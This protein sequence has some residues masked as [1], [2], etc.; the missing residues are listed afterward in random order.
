M[1][2]ASGL[3]HTTGI[4]EESVYGTANTTSMRG[5][6]VDSNSLA[7]SK[8]RAVGSG[9]RGGEL[10]ARASRTA[11]TSVMAEGEIEMDFATKGMG[12]WLRHC[13]GNSGISQIG[14]SAA[15]L[16]TFN[17][18]D[19]R[20]R[21]LTIMA[22]HPL[23][24][25]SLQPFTFTGCKVTEW[26]AS[27]GQGELLKFNASIDAQNGSLEASY[28]APSYT[29]ADAAGVLSWA[30]ASIY[31]NGSVTRTTGP[32]SFEISSSNGLATDRPRAGI[33]KAEPLQ[34]GLTETTVTIDSEFAD[35]ASWVARNHTDETFAVRVDF[36]GN[37]IT[38]A[39]AERVSFLLP[40]VKVNSEDPTVDG[41]DMLSQSIQLSA[42]SN[43][44]LS[45]IGVEYVSTDAA[46]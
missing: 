21:A 20:G 2:L 44:V 16:Q 6:Y 7:W 22:G 28:A 8:N 33:F 46:A 4:A 45:A 30:G 42:F 36:T 9:L 14:A 10:Y 13:L 11:V 5:Y 25:G 15:F 34:A 19:L 24:D 18:G 17:P 38:G 41:P 26:S 35:M 27:C 12:L 37:I 29:L 39:E 1:Q 32:S 3:G 23:A 31:V 40:A 43:G